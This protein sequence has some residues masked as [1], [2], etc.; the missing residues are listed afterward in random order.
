MTTH[1]EVA[2]KWAHQA[3]RSNRARGFNMYYEGD[4]IYSYGAHFPIA[5]IITR[6]DGAQCVLMTTRTYSVSTSKHCTITRRACSHFTR[7]FDVPFVEGTLEKHVA[8]MEYYRFEVKSALDRAARRRKPE[9]VEWDLH[10]AGNLCNEAERYAEFF[11]LDK[12]RKLFRIPALP[13]DIN[14]RLAELREAAAR[15]AAEQ[16]ERTRKRNEQIELVLVP[17]WRN[18]EAISLPHAYRSAHGSYIMRVRG[19]DIETSGGARFPVSDARRA[20]PILQR[21]RR[22]FYGDKARVDHWPQGDLKLG[23]YRVDKVTTQGVRAG[24]HFIVWDEIER[25]ARELGLV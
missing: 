4:T 2:H 13:D 11:K 22:A 3:G 8:N 6:E 7:R 14:A 24:C 25:M 17:A 21:V 9:Y 1:N 16:A 12:R 19:D 15:R 23:H 10:H 5:R 18:G 20:W